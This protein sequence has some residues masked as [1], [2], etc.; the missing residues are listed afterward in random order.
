MTKQHDRFSSFSP[1]YEPQY[2]TLLHD[3][4]AC[5]GWGLCCPAT[6]CASYPQQQEGQHA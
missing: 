6:E 1:F 2:R 3:G 5:A 4:D